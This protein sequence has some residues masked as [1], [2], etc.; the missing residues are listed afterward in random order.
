MIRLE[1]KSFLPNPKVSTMQHWWVSLTMTNSWN[2]GA[3]TTLV[4]ITP[5]ELLHSLPI[6]KTWIRAV[7]VVLNLLHVQSCRK[8][9][10]SILSYSDG[11][12]S[13]HQPNQIAFVP[14]RP[15]M[16]PLVS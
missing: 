8:I 16:K 11:H 5:Q 12:M 2:K 3:N 15:P 4:V 10:P 7:L 13:M 14:L 6:R 9:G 1:L